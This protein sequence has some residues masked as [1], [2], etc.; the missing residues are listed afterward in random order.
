MTFSQFL[1]L[2]AFIATALPL[3]AIGMVAAL[4]GAVV[5]GRAPVDAA[6][7]FERHAGRAYCWA[8]I[9]ILAAAILLSYGWTGRLLLLLVG[10]SFLRAVLDVLPRLEALRTGA[11]VIA[12]ADL[13]R[14]AHWRRI[15]AAASVIQWVAVLIV[16]AQ[17]VL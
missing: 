1:A 13:D 9:A 14:L 10:A 5:F 15:I 7:L 17:L 3:G 16:Y 11:P 8:M 4:Y 2:L 6:V 12:P